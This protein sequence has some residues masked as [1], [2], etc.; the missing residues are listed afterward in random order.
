MTTCYRTLVN[1]YLTFAVEQGIL[2][3][4]IAFLLAFMLW[5]LTV[6]PLQTRVSRDLIL[7]TRAS[8]LAFGVAGIFSTTMEDARLW[9]VPA[10]CAGTLA[11]AVLRRRSWSQCNAAIL[12]GALAILI[13]LGILEVASLM[14]G[15]TKPLGIALSSRGIAITPV[16]AGGGKARCLWV[17]VDEEVMGCDYG[18]LLRGLAVELGMQI[19]VNALPGVIPEGDRVLVSGNQV[20]RSGYASG[21]KLALLAPARMDRLQAEKILKSGGPID[22]LLPDFDEDGRTRF[23][24]DLADEL[25]QPDKIRVS[26]LPGVGIQV[27]W[28]WER[29]AGIVKKL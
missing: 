20:N 27:A 5:R 13:L 7:G 11:M 6:P 17:M 10:L 21:V 4:S 14:L 16:H 24:S 2:I 1:S 8:L 29:V 23:W 15:R 9:P 3:F 19:N 12:H 25:H 18:K 22:L 26:M 28:A